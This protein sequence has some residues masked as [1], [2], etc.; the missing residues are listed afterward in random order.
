MTLNGHRSQKREKPTGGDETASGVRPAELG[1]GN[2]WNDAARCT[3]PGERA[4]EALGRLEQRDA[5]LGR[6]ASF[7]GNLGNRGRIAV[8][9]DFERDAVEPEADP[10][11]ER[12]QH[13]FL[14]SPEAK[15]RRRALRL[16]HRIE[17]VGFALRKEAAREVLRIELAIDA[18]EIDA[19]RLVP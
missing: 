19:E 11:A 3:V 4:E 8:R 13:G 1:G 17:C 18:F 15:E 7:F 10:G 14:A 5:P 12:L 2:E 16:G 9:A 6:I